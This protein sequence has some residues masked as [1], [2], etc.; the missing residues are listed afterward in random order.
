MWGLREKKKATRPP[1]ALGRFQTRN[2]QNTKGLTGARFSHPIYRQLW[3]TRSTP[4]GR[5]PR[6]TVRM[7][8]SHAQE[9]GRTLR[10]RLSSGIF[11]PLTVVGLCYL[12]LLAL[13]PRL[14]SDAADSAEIKP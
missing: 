3:L 2:P 10:W 1:R 8:Y 9:A 14:L 4:R 13:G 6:G 5:P 12:L 11:W 7:A